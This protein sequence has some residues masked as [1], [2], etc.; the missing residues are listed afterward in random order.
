MPRCVCTTITATARSCDV[1]VATAG[2]TPAL[3]S[4]GFS[5]WFWD[6]D[7]DGW[8]DLYCLLAMKYNAASKRSGANSGDALK[9]GISGRLVS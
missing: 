3:R 6:Y 1:A 4:N 9:D 8:L 2:I 7:N 5:C